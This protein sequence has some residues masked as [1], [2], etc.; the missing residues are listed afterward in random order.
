MPL[1]SMDDFWLSSVDALPNMDSRISARRLQH[2]EVLGRSARVRSLRA[3]LMQR[4]KHGSPSIFPP[5]AEQL[6]LDFSW[7]FRREEDKLLEQLNRFYISG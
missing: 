4:S 1:L 7:G 2:S 3:L 5:K 6:A